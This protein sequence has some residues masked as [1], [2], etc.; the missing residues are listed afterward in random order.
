MAIRDKAFTKEMAIY[1]R[2]IAWKIPWTEEP[3][4][5]QFMGSQE[6]DDLSTK[7]PPPPPMETFKN[8][9]IYPRDFYGLEST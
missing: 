4:G 1:S 2:T 6:L 8:R 9:C 7:P 5:L 3:G